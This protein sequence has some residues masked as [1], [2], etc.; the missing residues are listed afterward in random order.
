MVRNHIL[1]RC[2]LRSNCVALALHFGVLYELLIDVIVEWCWKAYVC[3]NGKMTT[4][5]W[6]MVDV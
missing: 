4:L 5:V 1:Q 6:L 3:V 2:R